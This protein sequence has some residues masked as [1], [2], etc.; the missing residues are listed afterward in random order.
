MKNRTD[1]C[2]LLVPTVDTRPISGLVDLNPLQQE[3]GVEVPIPLVD[4]ASASNLEGTSAEKPLPME[5]ETPRAQRHGPGKASVSMHRPTPLPIAL[6]TKSDID[7][8]VAAES[9]SDSEIAPGDD[10]DLERGNRL[11]LRSLESRGEDPNGVTPLR[12]A[13]SRAS[14]EDT[15][16]LKQIS[17]EPPTPVITDAEGNLVTLPHKRRS[18]SPDEPESAKDL[19]QDASSNPPL[20][21]TLKVSTTKDDSVSGDGSRGSESSTPYLTP[22][23]S[24][25]ATSPSSTTAPAAGKSG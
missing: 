5:P 6:P 14:G 25:P 13:F 10:Q 8:D 15:L 18:L 20:V 21:S 23:D 24:M 7:V 4:N 2:P 11:P 22:L 3:S 17:V 16:L 9:L 1:L 19:V 12:S